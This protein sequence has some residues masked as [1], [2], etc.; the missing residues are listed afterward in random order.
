MTKQTLAQFQQQFTTQLLSEQLDQSSL[1]FL[2]QLKQ[3]F[4]Q[5]DALD[6]ATLRLNIYRNNV[7]FSL[8]SAIGDLYPIVKRLI[9]DECFNQAAIDFVRRYPPSHSALVFY[10]EGFIE[11]IKTYPACVTLE[12]LTD[13]AKLEYY[14]HSVFH[15]TDSDNLD[16]ALLAQVAPEQ[17]GQLVFK[18]QPADRLF[19]SP[20]PVEAIWQENLKQQPQFI[21]LEHTSGDYLLIYRQDFEVQVVNLNPHCYHFIEQLML[22]HNISEAWQ[23][24]VQQ[25]PSV[26]QPLDDDELGPILGY[27]L[28]LPLFA[29]FNLGPLNNE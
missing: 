16:P 7:I 2:S 19:K 8:S 4:P 1:E 12:Y 5:G 3:Q 23:H 20:W 18:L 11:F 28:S 29:T 15:E 14:S 24:T 27:L 6:E 26:N 17:L 13:V 10:G 22:G 25:A 9:G 21:E